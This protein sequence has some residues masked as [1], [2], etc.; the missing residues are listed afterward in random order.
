MRVLTTRTFETGISAPVNF[1]PGGRLAR[2]APATIT[3]LG[4]LVV[5]HTID[6]LLDYGPE[7][8][9]R[10]SA[11]GDGQTW[12]ATVIAVL[13]AVALLVI[14]ASFRIGYLVLRLRRVDPDCP[15]LRFSRTTYLTSVG[16][17][18]LR[19]FVASVPMFVI[20][21]NFEQWTAGLGLPGL[22]VL[23]GTGLV[24]PTLIF[25]L[26]SLVFALIVGLFTVGMAF[27]EA[28]IGRAAA[29]Q[30]HGPAAVRR[31]SYDLERIPWSVIA[32]NLAG[33]APPV[34]LVP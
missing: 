14:A 34:R 17:V 8:S 10:L 4:V 33:R 24:N 3:A 15:A 6:F 29:R 28:A 7:Y 22:Y 2:L 26:V 21:E 18:W 20:H 9:W 32:R 27:L 13:A 31:L 23:A 1:H 5:G 19:L 11:R 30:S 16:R 12:D 25:A